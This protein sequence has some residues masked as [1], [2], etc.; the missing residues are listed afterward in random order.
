MA[1]NGKDVIYVD[2]DDEITGIIDKVS[3]SSSKIVALV[4]PKRATVFQSIVNMKLLKKRADAAKK[5]PVLI[6]SESSLL[7]MAGSVGLY[8]AKT[9]QSKPEIPSA[10]TTPGHTAATAAVAAGAAGIAVHRHDEDD[11]TDDEFDA[12]EAADKPVGDL[13]GNS[14]SVKSINETPE[15]TIEIDNSESTD[16]SSGGKDVAAVAAAGAAG[17]AGAKKGKNHKLKVPNFDKFRMKLVLII[18]GIVLL[19]VGWVVANNV[20][21]KAT[22]TIKTDTS[23]VNSSLTPTLD[24]TADTVD[25]NSQ[26]VPAKVATTQKAYTA[27][28]SA[29]GKKNQGDKA[30]GSVQL[31]ATA[32][33][34]NLGTPDSIPAGSGLSANGLTFITQESAHFHFDGFSG[35]SCAKYTTDDV[36]ITA[37]KGGT[38]YNLGDGTNFTVAGSSSITGTGSTDGGTDDI[39]TVVQQSDIDSA[40]KQAE[41][42]IDKNALQQQLKQQL[43]GEGE[44][45]ITETF[46]SHPPKV[47]TSAKP[48]DQVANVTYTENIVYSMFGAQKSDLDKLITASVNQQIDANKQSI[49]DDGLDQAQITMPSPGTLAKTQIDMQVTS[50]IGPHLDENELKKSVAGSKAGEARSVIKGNPGVED[51]TVD[52]SPFWVE[53][54]PKNTDKITIVYTKSSNDGGQ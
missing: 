49:Q 6:T 20:L 24:T 12:Q 7:P 38:N 11:E 39:V 27:Q 30:T 35:G 42:G 53:T 2:V 45:A 41:Q 4:L 17:K 19:I 54:I 36:S 51:V 14:D 22:V 28:A 46:I 31:T 18:L 34:P 37:D 16:K 43:E 33:A 23:D 44:F 25:T 47:T 5:Q 8:V 10:T 52:L 48:G 21:P 26:V 50:V 40:K 9:L 3:N 15:D 1:S 13:A 32:C 29:S